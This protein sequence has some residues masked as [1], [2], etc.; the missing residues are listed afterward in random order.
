[1]ITACAG[2]RAGQA[3]TSPGSRRASCA[4]IPAAFDAGYAHSFEVWNEAG[5]LV[6]GGYG[7]AIGGCLHH[8]VAVLARVQHLEDRLQRCCNWHLAKWGYVFNDNKRMTPTCRNGL[9]R[10]SAAGI[11]RFADEHA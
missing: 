11:P 4:P 10:R 2:R 5:E 9:P 6:G 1:M 3:G 8:R 7:V